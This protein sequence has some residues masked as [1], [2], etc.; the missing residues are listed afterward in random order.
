MPWKRTIW[1]GMSIPKHRIV[2]WLTMR[3]GLATI[4]NMTRRGWMLPNR[5]CLCYKESE[6]KE[7]LFFEC[8]YSYQILQETLTRKR[9]RRI[10]TDLSQVVTYFQRKIKGRNRTQKA[11]RAALAA[12]IYEVWLERNHR[13]FQGECRAV[14]EVVRK[15]Q[16]MVLARYFRE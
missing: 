9:I 6:S 4:Q 14:K 10:Y 12:V 16:I 1:E 15:I 13:I 3:N 2:M 11:K 5:C 7:H 8:H